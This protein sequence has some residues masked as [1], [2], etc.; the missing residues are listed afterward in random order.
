MS[1][2][3]RRIGPVDVI[4]ISADRKENEIIIE[5][6]DF[7]TVPKCVNDCIKTYFHKKGLSPYFQWF[8]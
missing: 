3:V 5:H 1:F 2:S 6:H 4:D 8:V 7:V